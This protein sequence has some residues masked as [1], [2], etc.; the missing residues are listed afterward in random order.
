MTSYILYQHNLFITHSFKAGSM[1]QHSQHFYRSW[2][3]FPISWVHLFNVSQ[4]VW[5][6][7]CS[8]AEKTHSFISF[9]FHY[10]SFSKFLFWAL[11]WQ[12]LLHGS[13]Y[14]TTVDYFNGFSSVCTQS[15]DFLRS[16]FL[17]FYSAKILW[18][19]MWKV[20]LEMDF[21]VGRSCM[22]IVT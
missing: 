3:S 7:H 1:A 21:K 14:G 13:P 19:L 2:R 18:T 20:I 5:A 12:M 16:W 4:E 6:E 22:F 15:I 11:L 8:A 17:C 10:S 9:K